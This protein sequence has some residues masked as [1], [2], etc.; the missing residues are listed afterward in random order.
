MKEKHILEIL[1]NKSFAELGKDELKNLQIHSAECA[2]C[3]RAF[4]AARISSVLL[5]VRAESRSIAPSPF[6]QAK[7][8]NAIQ[9][10][11]QNLRNPIAALRRWWQAS[12]PLVC[13][14][15]LVVI[16]FITLT[17]L[18]P[19]SNAD[20]AQAVTNYNLYTTESVIL[21]QRSPR[22]LTDEQALE[23]IY[24]TRNDPNKK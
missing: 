19:T 23:V 10:E 18:A 11:S 20:D 16:G 21:N 17:F 5:G 3:N 4:E 13:S 22:N 15:L 2:D 14:M 1:D 6:F 9:L 24:S 7:V 8:M 12:Y